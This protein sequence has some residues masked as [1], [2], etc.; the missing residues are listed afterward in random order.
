MALEQNTSSPGA[1][2]STSATR[3]R[4]SSRRCLARWPS[5]CV[6]VGLAQAPATARAWAARAS[7]SG[8][9]E[10]LASK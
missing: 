1:A 4:A 7:G 9:A 2:P 3:R 6:L 10:A 5:R 8:G